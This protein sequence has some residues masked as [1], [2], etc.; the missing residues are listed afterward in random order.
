MPV[1]H[2]GAMT[3]SPAGQTLYSLR[4]IL[5]AHAIRGLRFDAASSCR[6]LAGCSRAP[7]LWSTGGIRHKCRARDIIRRLPALRRASLGDRICGSATIRLP[8]VPTVPP[9]LQ[10]RIFSPSSDFSRLCRLE[11]CSRHHSQGRARRV[12]PA[13]LA[14][15]LMTRLSL[16]RTKAARHQLTMYSDN[17]CSSDSSTNGFGRMPTDS[18]S[19][20]VD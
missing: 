7:P 2:D 9:G 18:A 17:T 15:T 10:E 12:A 5:P 16:S 4:P 19:A 11:P 8:C 20:R 14:P 6:V 1:Q 13:V 3:A